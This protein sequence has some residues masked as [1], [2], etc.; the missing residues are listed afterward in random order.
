MPGVPDAGTG[1]ASAIGRRAVILAY[2]TA[3]V[4]PGDPP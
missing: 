4:V 3:I 1:S 2:E